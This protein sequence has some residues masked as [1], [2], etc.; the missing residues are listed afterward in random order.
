[1]PL[2]LDGTTGISASGNI[3]AAY[4][5]GN[6]SQLA[7]ISSSKIYNGT[8]EAN[9]GAS[10]GNANISIGG[11]ANVAVFSSSGLIITGD[12]SVTGNATLSGNILGDKIENGTT[13]FEIQTFGGNANISIGGTSN[14]AVF[15][16]S[17][18]QVTGVMSA[19]GNVTG[20]NILTSGLISAT[21]N[22][23][24]AATIKAPNIDSTNADVAEKYVADRAYPPGTVLEIGGAAEVQATTVYASARIAGVVSTTPALLM[25]STERDPHSVELALL[26]RVPCRVTGTVHRGDLVTSS[27]Q[28]GVATALDPKDYRPGCVVGKALQG[29]AGNGEGVIEVLVGRL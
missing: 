21:G 5:F 13:S 11:V 8:S 15:T 9:I 28:P 12:L 2:S 14:V 3:T 7:G 24:S 1:M 29:H 25:N 16:T 18:Q 20:G 4:L 10:G 6:A 17:G 22:I 19:S 26:G 27:D 23:T